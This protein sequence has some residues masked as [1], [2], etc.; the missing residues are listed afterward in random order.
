MNGL[1]HE[2][3]ACKTSVSDPPLGKAPTG[4]CSYQ[5]PCAWR[6]RR[7][8]PASVSWIPLSG[9]RTVAM[10]PHLTLALEEIF[11]YFKVALGV[12]QSVSPH[13]QAMSCQQEAVARFGLREARPDVRGQSRDIL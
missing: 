10:H 5:T 13:V 7:T 11:E 2:S 1:S 4:R 12:H 3:A 9:T 6:N 8:S